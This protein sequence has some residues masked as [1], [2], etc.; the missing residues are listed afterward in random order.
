VLT[1]GPGDNVLRL[2]PPMTISDDELEQ[3]LSILKDALAD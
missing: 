3:G 1:C 2:I